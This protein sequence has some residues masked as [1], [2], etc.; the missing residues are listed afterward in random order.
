[1]AKEKTTTLSF[2]DTFFFLAPDAFMTHWQMRMPLGSG[3]TWLCL[4]D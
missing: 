3:Y 2:T 1:M 4:R